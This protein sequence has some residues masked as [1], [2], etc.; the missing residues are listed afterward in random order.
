M[1]SFAV[2]LD[3]TVKE[4]RKPEKPLQESRRQHEA[5]DRDIHNLKHISA[6]HLDLGHAC[7]THICDLPF[8]RN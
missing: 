6:W 7:I 4:S 5:H 3:Q 1:L 2:D 8:V